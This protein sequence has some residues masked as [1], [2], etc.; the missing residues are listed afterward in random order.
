MRSRFHL[1]LAAFL[2]I[3][4]ALGME[5][6]GSYITSVADLEVWLRAHGQ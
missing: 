2:Y 3:G 6:V 4:G 5:M 1:M